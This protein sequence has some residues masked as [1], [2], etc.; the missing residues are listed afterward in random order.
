MPC[1]GQHCGEPVQSGG[2][3]SDLAP[4]SLHY[5]PE[6]E[7]LLIRRLAERAHVRAEMV[8]HLVSRPCGFLLVLPDCHG[9]KVTRTIPSGF[10][11]RRA[12]HLCS[13]PTLMS[14]SNV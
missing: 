14:S 3:G 8:V 5:G 12:C 11:F 13:C 2:D 1:G 9:V 7:S 10:Q 4:V 6:V